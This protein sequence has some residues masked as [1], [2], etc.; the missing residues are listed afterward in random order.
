VRLTVEND[1][2]VRP[3]FQWSRKTGVS[4]DCRV[5]VLSEWGLSAPTLST[6][7]FV[8]YNYLDVLWSNAANPGGADL[9]DITLDECARIDEI[10]ALVD[11]DLVSVPGGSA[12]VPPNNRIQHILIPNTAVGRDRPP[13]TCR[14]HSSA[15]RSRTGCA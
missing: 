10:P 3:S 11:A 4:R 15:I 12:L 1:A 9:L 14:S 6:G 7:S 5:S 13:R 2:T 8:I